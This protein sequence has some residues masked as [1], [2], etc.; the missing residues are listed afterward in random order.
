MGFKIVMIMALLAQAFAALL[1]LRL[2]LRYRIYSAWLFISASAAIGAVMMLSTLLDIWR[3]SPSIETDWPLW[4]TTHAALL[5]SGLL[6]AGMALIEPFFQQISRAQEALQREHRR[7]STRVKATED[8]LRI[9]RQIQQSFL[10]P[11]CP[12]FDRVDV[13]GASEPA[14]WTS[15]DYFDY[16]TLAGGG[17]VFL[18]ADVC[19]HGLGPALLMMSTRATIR[20]L[21]PAVSE[22]GELLTSANAA[23]G[24]LVADGRFVT[25]FAAGYDPDYRR[26]AFAA[27]GHSAYLQ[28]ADGSRHVVEGDSAPLGVLPHSPVR[29]QFQTEVASGD[30]LVL[31]TDGILENTN[32]AGEVFGEERLLDTVAEHGHLEAEA[33]VTELFQAVRTFSDNEPQHDDITAIVAKFL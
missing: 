25:A 14:D 1:A 10:P 12:S 19:G 5:A 15:G 28:G 8:E 27:A 20:A 29:T 3:Q 32:S 11:V 6:L 18:I 31:V 17:N 24:D 7:L 13:H 26:L 30:M 16:M 21:A 23:L 33:I 9:A 2:N 22:V 4:T